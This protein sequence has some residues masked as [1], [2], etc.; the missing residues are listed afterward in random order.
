M[1]LL[2]KP[3]G[4]VVKIDA[5]LLALMYRTNLWSAM[6]WITRNNI[7]TSPYVGVLKPSVYQ[8]N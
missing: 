1:T 3:E 7:V 6:D 8:S 2:D 5:D 4:R